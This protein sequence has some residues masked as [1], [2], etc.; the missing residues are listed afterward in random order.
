MD[1]DLIFCHTAEHLEI[2]VLHLVCSW[3]HAQQ[4]LPKSCCCGWLWS[5]Y[6]STSEGGEVT[7]TRD[8]HHQQLLLM[9]VLVVALDVEKWAMPPP[10]F[11]GLREALRMTTADLVSR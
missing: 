11:E 10:Q 4:L 9:H 2:Q 3:S 7:Y 1:V 6:C 5:L 8:S